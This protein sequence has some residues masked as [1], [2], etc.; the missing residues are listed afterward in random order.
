M[1]N[2]LTPFKTLTQKER[3]IGVVSLISIIMIL[4]ESSNSSF[5]P[6]PISVM[7]SIPKLIMSNDLIDNFMKS[8]FFCFKAIFY[9]SVI[10]VIICYLAVIP[11]FT[12]FCQFLRKFRFLPSAG[13]S[14]L[15]MKIS[16]AMESGV[17]GQMMY[18]MVFGVSTWLI[19][20]MVGVSL[21]I[22]PEDIMYAKSLRLSRWEMM[23]ELLIKGK[24]GQLI[25]CIISNFAIAWMLLASI[26]N[27][28]KADGGIGVILSDSNKY[29][30]YEQVYAIQILILL[31][32]ISLDFILR[33]VKDWL[34]PYEK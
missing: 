34:I 9:S 27:I 16:V 26:E 31:T 22:G 14:F 11:L 18:M 13:L 8:L 23:R 19:D 30:K 33:K 12:T 25:M 28:A 17:S 32:G 3:V 20:S 1:I 10:S 7:M 6:S 2:L 29:F 15:F 21:S 4:W 24:A 5:I